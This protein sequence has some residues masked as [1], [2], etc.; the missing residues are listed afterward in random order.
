MPVALRVTPWPDPVLDVLGHDP[1]S[2][3]AETFWLP[4]SRPDRAAPHAASRRPVRAHARGRRAGGGRHRSR[5]GPRRERRQQLTVD[6]EP[7]PA[8]SVRVGVQRERDDDRGAAHA[9][10]R[11]PPSRAPAAGGAPGHPRGVDG[12][13]ASGADRARPPPRPARRARR[14]SR[15]ERRSTPSSARCT[16]PDITLR[17]RTKRSVGRATAN[18]S[19][20]TTPTSRR[21]PPPRTPPPDPKVRRSHR[22]LHGR[23][24]SGGRSAYSQAQIRR[25]GQFTEVC[26]GDG[27]PEVVA[28]YS[29][30]QIRR[31]GQF[32][33]VC[34][35][36]GGPEVVAAYRRHYRSRSPRR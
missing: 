1:R 15:R 5:A 27:G 16:T 29:Q 26:T 18:V 3:Y 17:S 6:A 23:W 33:E 2:W 24:R 10:A 12:R 14:S 9:A 4:D 36:D 19:S 34:T 25:T 35:G 30:A 20:T 21:W 8:P 28:A 32:T 22:S 11:A 31:T 7:R 13:P